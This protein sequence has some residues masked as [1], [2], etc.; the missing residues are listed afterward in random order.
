MFSILPM[1]SNP[2]EYLSS[3]VI[4]YIIHLSFYLSLIFNF[5]LT[6]MDPG[7]LKP[8]C[9]KNESDKESQL[10]SFANFSEREAAL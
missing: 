4:R 5:A 6:K 3:I 2:N 1:K 8:I 9:D 7:K 10:T